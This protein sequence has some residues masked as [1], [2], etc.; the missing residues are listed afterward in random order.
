MPASFS[1]SIDP[2]DTRQPRLARK[3]RPQHHLPLA[4]S[5]SERLHEELYQ[6]TLPSGL[7]LMIAP[8]PGRRVKFASVCARFGSLDTRW[9]DAQGKAHKV[10]DGVAHFLE[11]Q[12]FKKEDGDLSDVFTAE[13]AYINAH[14]TYGSTTYYFETVQGFDSS[15]E[16]LLRLAFEPWFSQ[17]LV[18]V[19]KEIIVQE[20]QQYADMPAWAVYQSLMKGLYHKHPVR[21]DI[22]GSIE[23]V[24][25]TSAKHLRTCHQHFYAP[26]NCNLCIAGDVD[27]QAITAEVQQWLEARGYSSP[28][29]P[30]R[31]AH[32]KEPASVA[33]A[34]STMQRYVAMPHA[35]VGYRMP[36]VKP[37]IELVKTETLLGIAMDVVFG[38][39]SGF[40]EEAYQQ[41]LITSGFSAGVQAERDYCLIVIGGET[42]DPEALQKAITQEIDQMLL[43]GLREADIERARHKVLGRFLGGFDSPESTALAHQAAWLGGYDLFS[44]DNLLRDFT[45]AEVMD[46]C[47]AIFQPHLRSVSAILPAARTGSGRSRRKAVQS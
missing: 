45:S 40:F 20:L 8:R 37:G 30:V 14:T 47:R 32:V 12:L 21:V 35:L 44:Y 33:A 31:L 1:S 34:H 6:T 3:H 17:D 5:T 42:P 28:I 4:H 41:G 7:T 16:N 24:R 19:E 39:S 13:G 15:L 38:A 26:S 36:S 22:G 43:G 11:H 10:P 2:S 25:N 29:A 18:E 27:P 46:A 23:S 9:T